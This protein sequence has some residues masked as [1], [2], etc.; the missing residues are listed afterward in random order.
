MLSVPGKDSP[1]HDC[2]EKQLFLPAM[3]ARAAP[4]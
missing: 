3:P 1:R 2:R 4:G